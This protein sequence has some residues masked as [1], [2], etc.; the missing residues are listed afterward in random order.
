MRSIL[1]A[2]SVIFYFKANSQA[3]EFPRYNEV[4][5]VATHNSYWVKRAH[6]HEPFATGTQERLLDQLHFDHA[7]ALE[8][9]IHKINRKR[10]QW[11]IY[12]TGKVKN[13][14]Y[15]TLPEFLKQ[16]QQF[17]YSLPKHE[18]V[19]VVLELKQIFGDNFDKNHTPADLDSILESYLG[20]YLFR[21]RDLM[22]RCPG[23]NTLC[24]CAAASSEVWPTIDE[25]R[26]KFIF[27]VLG[28][29][30]FGP[31]GHGGMGWA[32][33]ANS[34]DPSAFPMS[35]DFSTFNK[36]K[37]G[38]KISKQ[39]LT[40]AYQ[41]SV[42]QQVENVDDTA[43]LKEISKYIG[44]GGMV[45]GGSSFSIKEQ[46]QRIGARFHFLQTDFPWVGLNDK[47]YNRPFRPIDSSRFNNPSV[48][49]EPGQRIL[50]SADSESFWNTTSNTNL[51]DWETLPSTTRT[52][53]NKKFLNPLHAYGK[54]CLKASTVD[55]RQSV[56]VC[57]KV[58][59]SQNA[60]VT[61]KA[62][63]D[64]M[65]TKT[66]FSSNNNT[67]GRIGDYIRMTVEQTEGKGSV[68]HI[69]SSSVMT[70]DRAGKLSPQW[71]KIFSKHFEH[72]LSKQ[73]IAASDGDVL[74]VGTRLNGLAV[75]S[76]AFVMA[77]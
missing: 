35:S 55:G 38:E 12:H 59:T 6:V 39:M 52:S 57:R 40:C 56:S 3:K 31:I 43:H 23:K 54:G 13:V 26:G 32:T 4:Y 67:S 53:P 27:L 76:A 75:D 2:L 10:G 70:K 71:N 17:Q 44:K 63:D 65:V 25:L 77:Q 60:V 15:A 9:D 8:I 16:L 14:F 41:A 5:Q 42:F 73:G 21:P 7:R 51:N 33:Y 68:V 36:N 28:N 24:D 62:I 37:G 18:V 34:K 45:R 72:S 50:V 61:V 29:L 74:F 64:K 69:Y 58:N 30:H 11:A 20:E 46:R 22:K 48:F 47:G 19:T 49:I 66:K 1:F